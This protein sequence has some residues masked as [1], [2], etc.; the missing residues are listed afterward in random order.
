MEKKENINIL[1][2]L[3][4]MLKA[5]SND[6]L[7]GIFKVDFITEF[8]KYLQV[9]YTLPFT[10]A[11]DYLTTI[12]VE[13]SI[14][15]VY[16]VGTLVKAIIN[17]YNKYIVTLD[18]NEHCIELLLVENGLPFHTPIHKWETKVDVELII[19]EIIKYKK[20]GDSKDEISS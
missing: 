5:V 18:G 10:E 11:L 15:M 3:L 14:T 17:V 9:D 12:D 1:Q 2:E 19:Q 16:S 8:A 13:N 4:N 20:K 6:D 7:E